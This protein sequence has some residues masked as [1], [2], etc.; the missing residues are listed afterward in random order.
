MGTKATLFMN[1][2]I[3]F[4]T[5]Q[6]SANHHS[7]SDD[8]EAMRADE[9]KAIFVSARGKSSTGSAFN[10]SRSVHFSEGPEE[11][12][13]PYPH[14][15]HSLHAI[16]HGHGHSHSHSHSHGAAPSIAMVA[17]GVGAEGDEDGGEGEAAA[18]ALTHPTLPKTSSYFVQT[19]VQQLGQIRDGHDAKGE[20]GGEEG[21]ADSDEND[22]LAVVDHAIAVSEAVAQ[23]AQSEPPAPPVDYRRMLP[24]LNSRGLCKWEN[25]ARQLHLPL[26]LV[27]LAVRSKLGALVDLEAEEEEGEEEEEDGFEG[28]G[29]GLALDGDETE[30]GDWGGGGVGGGGLGS[31]RQAQQ[32]RHRVER[33]VEEEE[34]EDIDQRMEG[35]AA[36][37]H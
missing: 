13:H 21:D 35:A 28:E 31:G 9:K 37:V 25:L 24:K 6:T 14:H 22:A 18:R 36:A 33:S 4:V 27:K 10:S 12:L 7:M 1:R 8:S 20:G 11:R 3:S 29:V 2:F 34:E 16:H 15:P 19:R 17:E 32:L 23:A 30:A 5:R 26:H